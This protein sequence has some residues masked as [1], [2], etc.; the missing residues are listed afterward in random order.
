MIRRPP[1]STLFPYTTLFRSSRLFGPRRDF[2]I[3]DAQA[4][5][6][7]RWELHDPLEHSTLFVARERVAALEDP[8]GR[9]GIETAGQP[10]ELMAVPPEAARGRAGQAGGRAGPAPG[11]P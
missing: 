2:P 1:R 3:G 7:T 9:Q 8:E 11:P 6:Q 5:A 10:R 4:E